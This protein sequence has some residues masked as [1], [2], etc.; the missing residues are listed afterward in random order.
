MV[1][2]SRQGM[3]YAHIFTQAVAIWNTITTV[4]TVAR[5]AITTVA[6]KEVPLKTPS[7][8]TKPARCRSTT[9]TRSTSTKLMLLSARALRL[10][11]C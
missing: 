2:M 1:I 7:E 10:T 5:S 3:G 6:K 4:Q 8:V 9:P 11:T